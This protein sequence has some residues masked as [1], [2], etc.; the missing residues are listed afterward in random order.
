VWYTVRTTNLTNFL[1]ETC[2]VLLL[3]MPYLRAHRMLLAELES[4]SVKQ[5]D[6]SKKRRKMILLVA[7]LS[8]GEKCLPCDGYWQFVQMIVHRVLG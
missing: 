6:S 8:T 3:V 4:L 5:L 7:F 1:L 2:Y